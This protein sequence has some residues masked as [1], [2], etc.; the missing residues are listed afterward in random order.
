M[1]LVSFAGLLS[2]FEH[3]RCA[4][5]CKTD[6]GTDNS[7]V[8]AIPFLCR[9][10]EVTMLCVGTVLHLSRPVEDLGNVA[11]T[12]AQSPPN[13]RMIGELFVHCNIYCERSSK[14]WSH[15]GSIKM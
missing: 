13:T 1:S 3:S 11:A 8:E 7:L 4:N 5:P 9:L 6:H 15:V 12:L 10:G 14:F 2:A